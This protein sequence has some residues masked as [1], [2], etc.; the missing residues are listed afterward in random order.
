MTD[1]LQKIREEVERLRNIHQ[2]K[3]QNLDTNDNMCL[4][5]CGKR[6]LCNELL[7]F[8]DSLPEEPVSDDFEEACN[9]M[10]E[11][12]RISKCEAGKP[13]FSDG[14]YKL[15]FKAGANWQTQKDDEMLTA[16]YMD[17][18]EKGKKMM[19]EQMMKETIDFLKSYRRET[20]DKTGYIAGIIDDTTIED[21]RKL[22]ED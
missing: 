17:G 16:V 10:S 14:D 7:S 4:V 22:W 13:F 6:N 21:Y 11:A 8:I 12:A 9:Q 15:G 18:V 2:I 3:Y 19:R 1:K 5:E 20:P